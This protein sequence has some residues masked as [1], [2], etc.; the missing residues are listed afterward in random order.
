M[1]DWRTKDGFKP[2]RSFTV[3]EQVR[4]GLHDNS[5][6]INVIE[7]AKILLDNVTKN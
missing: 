7:N 5:E 6:I 1:L 3:G 4:V 2:T